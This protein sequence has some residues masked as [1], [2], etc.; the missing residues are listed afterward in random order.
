MQPTLIGFRLKR[1]PR[2]PDVLFR[3]G[4]GVTPQYESDDINGAIALDTSG[5]LTRHILANAGDYVVQGCRTIHGE[6]RGLSVFDKMNPRLP[7][8]WFRIPAGAKIP[9]GIALTRDSDDEHSEDAI[10]YTVAPKD[11]M[12]LSLFL[13]HLKELAIDV[14]PV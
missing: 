3:D 14:Q 8:T 11:D 6:H 4:K 2:K 1:G 9:P 5:D 7:F 13:Q 12:P 10:H